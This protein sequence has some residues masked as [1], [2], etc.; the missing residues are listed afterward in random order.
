MSAYKYYIVYYDT[1]QS[2]MQY[3]LGKLINFKILQLLQSFNF[4]FSFSAGDKSHGSG[5]FETGCVWCWVG[6][7]SLAHARKC[8]AT[9][10]YPWEDHRC[11]FCLQW[12][13]VGGH[14]SLAIVND[15]GN[16]LKNYNYITV[17][18]NWVVGGQFSR[19]MSS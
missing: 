15:L 18:I 16:Y 4:L 3:M 14:T 9:D 2:F 7:Q 11:L 5:L 12:L 13:V 1:I 8:S 19:E 17:T 10:V 6:N